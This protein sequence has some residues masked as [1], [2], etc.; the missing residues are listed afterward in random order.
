MK[1]RGI[2]IAC[3]MA[4]AALL[5][6]CEEPP[7]PSL[8]PV[9]Q[10]DDQILTRADF[11]LYLDA[12]LLREGEGD[13]QEEPSSANESARVLS[14]LFDN[15]I[16]EQA[17]LREAERRG[18]QVS[19]EE[20]SAWI[21]SEAGDTRRA[22]GA[23]NDPRRVRARRD[24]AI[25]KLLGSNARSR[26][27]VTPDEIEA[28]VAQHRE[29]ASP[30]RRLVLR[31]LLVDSD[32][33]ART[34][35]EDLERHRTSFAAAAAAAGG[36]QNQGQPLE[37]DLDGLP[38]PVRAEV[39]RLSPGEVS[40]PVR[41]H[42]SLFLFQ[43]DAWVAGDGEERLRSQAREELLRAKY[44]EASR[45]L[46]DEVKSAAHVKLMLENLPFRYVAEPAG[47]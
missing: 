6:S 26:A 40:A 44:A 9:A 43:V 13:G 8:L 23:G 34:I 29:S 38:E 24:L 3:W 25:Q 31:S 12:N 32:E 33:Q 4:V 19:D 28:Y 7:D 46:L 14:R 22:D 15:F 39:S 2:S 16:D 37:V 18:I 1:D 5:V 10:I 47:D 21:P 41:V 42:G 30:E 35:H 17:L 11:Q 36:A 27:T 20:I 45:R